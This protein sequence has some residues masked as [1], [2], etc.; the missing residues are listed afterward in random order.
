MDNFDRGSQ[1]RRVPA[2]S[3]PLT[4]SL[5]G[6]EGRHEEQSAKTLS[7]A[8]DTVVNRVA[9]CRRQ[10]RFTFGNALELGVDSPPPVIHDDR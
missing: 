2:S 7:F 4:A 8:C 5:Y 3:L 6:V 9:Q 10:L 1:R